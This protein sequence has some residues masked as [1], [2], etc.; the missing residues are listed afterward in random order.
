MA[1]DSWVVKR[2]GFVSPVRTSLREVKVE[3]DVTDLEDII[4]A[5]ILEVDRKYVMTKISNQLDPEILKM[6]LM[7]LLILRIDYVTREKKFKDYDLRRYSVPAFLAAYMLGI[8]R[9]ED[10]EFGL[11]LTPVYTSTSGML[12]PDEMAKFSNLIRALR[13]AFRPV[14][15]PTDWKGNIE[16]MSKFTLNLAVKSYRGRDH[17]VSAFLSSVISKTV[18]DEVV[19]ALSTVTY[20][21]AY[22]FRREIPISELEHEKPD[23]EIRK[24]KDEVV[25]QPLGV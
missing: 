7:T 11:I 6:Y 18:R 15:F 24:P 25:S 20:G 17:V 3:I 5:Y 14:D 13:D 16:F 23:L 4:D 10:Q 12:S 21:D 8:G 19:L 1:L 22:I 2:F 9:V